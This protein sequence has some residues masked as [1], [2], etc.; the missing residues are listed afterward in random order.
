MDL[1]DQ[2]AVHAGATTAGEIMSSPAIT[3]PLGSTRTLIADTL[4]QHRISA[5]PVVGDTGRV[6]GLVSE[7][8]LLAKSDELVDHLMTTSVISVSEDTP[9]ED[10]RH[11]LVGR[12]IRRVPVLREGVLVG[13]V[14]RGD[15]V[16]TMATEWACQVCGEPVRGVEAPQRCPKCHA[17]GERFVRQEQPPGA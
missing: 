1:R 7:Y 12:R 10:I 13:V 14:S 17:G 6:V 4:T 11:L 8:D 2:P 5:V 15:V 3:L 16:A 9:V